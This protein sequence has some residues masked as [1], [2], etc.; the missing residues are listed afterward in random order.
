M[1]AS[2]HDTSMR[3]EPSTC[4]NF[5]GSPGF[6]QD[7]KVISSNGVAVYKSVV[8]WGYLSVSDSNL[9]WLWGMEP[10]WPRVL[11]LL[12]LS[13]KSTAHCL[14]SHSN[15]FYP[16]SS[17]TRTF[18]KWRCTLCF[19]YAAIDLDSNFVPLCCVCHL[20]SW[21]ETCQTTCSQFESHSQHKSVFL[22]GL[23]RHRYRRH[24]NSVLFQTADYP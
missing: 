7:A 6:P 12:L 3:P 18:N 1:N 23:S 20:E 11:F 16:L 8:V 22:I 5:R 21:L 17:Q 10:Q 13:R 2:S 15:S 4:T 14:T 9:L 24:P 19:Q